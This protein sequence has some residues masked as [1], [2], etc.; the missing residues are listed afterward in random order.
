MA[1]EK[2]VSMLK[3]DVAAWNKWREDNREIS[4]NLSSA[5]LN[6]ANLSRADLAHATLVHADLDGANLSY[7]D[8]SS[9]DLSAATLIHADLRGATLREANLTHAILIQATLDRAYL[10]GA[11]LSYADLSA[12][13]LRGANLSQA[14][15]IQAYL[16]G[17]NLDGANLNGSDLDGANLAKASIGETSFDN[18]DLSEV[19]GL[20]NIHHHSP[21]TIG[22]DTIYRSK[23][24]I[25]EI[26]LR[27]IGV[28]D[29]F[30]TY[31]KSLTGVAFDFYSCFISYSTKDQAFAER[32]HA[33]LQA[34]GVRCWYAPEDI[35]GGK[36]IHEQIDH[37]I[38]VY[39]KLLVILSEHSMNSEWVKTEVYNA[40]QQEVTENR[41][42]LFPLSLV[43]Y[44]TVRNW[45]AFDADI[46]KD[47]ARE[48]REYFIP[49]FTHWK[50]HDAYQKAFNRLLRD[51]KA[52]ASNKD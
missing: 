9:S 11:N 13:T 23:G 12:A 27:G 35:Q 37:A 5:N 42:K 39:D 3:Q 50:D 46:G 20:E 40:R 10:N 25:P 32:L 45:K 38:R 28:P 30:I 18:L 14:Y 52:E 26:F 29:S 48:V 31:M 1:N 36:K 17:A 41:R 22:I 21:S 6:G 4:P 49:D 43:A 24:N 44:E 16:D 8:L 7:A 19:K 33:D 47:M 15:L 34:K 51:L 2:H